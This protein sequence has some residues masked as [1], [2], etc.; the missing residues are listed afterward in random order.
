M[1]GLLGV[2]AIWYLERSNNL[3][4]AVDPAG[5]FQRIGSNLA[6]RRFWMYADGVRER[7]GLDL[8]ETKPNKCSHEFASR[9]MRCLVRA[10]QNGAQ[11]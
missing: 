10:R 2:P 6:F 4:R 7:R 1:C 11:K 5:L 3:L 9:R 8:T